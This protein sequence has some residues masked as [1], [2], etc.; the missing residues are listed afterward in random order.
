MVSPRKG[1]RGQKVELPILSKTR[2]LE[3]PCKGERIMHIDDTISEFFGALAN[4]AQ[5]NTSSKLQ[6]DNVVEILKNAGIETTG[7]S[8]Y[9]NPSVLIRKAIDYW[10]EKDRPSVVEN[11]KNTL[12]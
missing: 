9:S 5:K 2:R 11:I 12:P 1:M 7:G 8:S 10:T 3:P 6:K 4:M